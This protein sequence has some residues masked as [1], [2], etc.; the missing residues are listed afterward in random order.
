MAI[1]RFDV[2]EPPTNREVEERALTALSGSGVLNLVV[3][4]TEQEVPKPSDKELAFNVRSIGR[5]QELSMLIRGSTDEGAH[6]IVRT[7]LETEGSAT[8]EFVTP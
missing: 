1:Q 3:R 7:S 5:P 8:A 6:I 4:S 2:I